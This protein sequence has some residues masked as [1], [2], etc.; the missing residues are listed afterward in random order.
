[1]AL[2]LTEKFR[3]SE[4]GRQFRNYE[5]THDE[6]TSTVYAVSMDLEYI[7]TIIGAHTHYSSVPVAAGTCCLTIAANHKSIVMSIPAKAASYTYLT[8]MGW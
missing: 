2:T 4:G 6:A 3:W 1:M 7:E 5:I 8:V